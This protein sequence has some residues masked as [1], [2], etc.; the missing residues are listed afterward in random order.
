MSSF[1]IMG[2]WRNSNIIIRNETTMDE[3]ILA[4]ASYYIVN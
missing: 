3:E 2:V 1:I 4:I